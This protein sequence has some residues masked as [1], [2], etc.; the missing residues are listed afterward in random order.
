MKVGDKVRTITTAGARMVA[1]DGK[2]IGTSSVFRESAIIVAKDC[3]LPTFN[4]ETYGPNDT[5]IKVYK[6]GRLVF[7]RMVCLEPLEHTISF[8]GGEP[9]TISDQSYQA[10]KK[11]LT[12]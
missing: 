4:S 3:I 8:D 9:V 2:I 12:Q 11:S 7:T 1:N 6:T 5:I 10:L